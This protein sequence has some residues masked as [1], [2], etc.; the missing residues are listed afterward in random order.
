MKVKNKVDIIIQARIGSTRFRGKI[1]KKH[2]NYFPL[3]ILIERLKKCANVSNIIICTTRLAEDN[4]IVDFCK[5]ENISFFRGHRNDLLSRY[6]NTAR[7]FKSNIIIR[8]TSDCP[9]IDYS[10]VNKMLNYF[11]KNKIDYYANT[12]PLPTTYPDGMDIEIFNY[13]TL[14]KTYKKAILPSEREHVTPYMFNSKKFLT[15]K[16]SLRKD[17]SKFRFCIDYYEDFVF[18]KKLLDHFK[19]RIYDLR[20]KDLIKYVK[21][22]QTIIKYQNKIKRNEGWSTALKKDE[23]FK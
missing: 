8:V 20:M 11:L 9:L 4:V 21:K 16:T 10:I 22:N 7:K 12:Y 5:R 17:L 6:F 3:K 19:D 13:S 2:K 1:F 18:F 23:K 15:K 14:E